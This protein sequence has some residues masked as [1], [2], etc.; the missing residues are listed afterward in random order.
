MQALP[1]RLVALGPLM[2]CSVN[3]VIAGLPVQVKVGLVVSEWRG[4]PKFRVHRDRCR[5]GKRENQ[6]VERGISKY[7]FG[8]TSLWRRC[9]TTPQRSSH[10]PSSRALRTLLLPRCRIDRKTLKRRTFLPD[11]GDEL[12]EYKARSRWRADARPSA[13]SRRDNGCHD[14]SRFVCPGGVRNIS[15]RPIP[16]PA[17]R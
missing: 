5:G 6:P 12:I 7:V 17:R 11:V 4:D 14:M 3:K 10:R 9:R 16:L 13:R 1:A 2:S 8:I 15:G